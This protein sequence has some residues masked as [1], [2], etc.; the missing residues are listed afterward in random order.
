MP[1]NRGATWVA[2]KRVT[3]AQALTD[4]FRQDPPETRAGPIAVAVSGGSDSLGLLH[5]LRDWARAQADPP[6]LVAVT[7]DHGLRPAAAEEALRVSSICI[8]LGIPHDVLRWDDW[9]GAGNLQDQARRARYRLIGDW[10]QQAGIA[11]VALGHTRDDNIET[12]LMGLS[13]GA[14]L[15]GLSGM[16]RRFIRNAVEFHRPLLNTTRSALRQM[17]EARGQDWIDDPSNED[18]RF[19]R[20]RLRQALATLDLPLDQLARSIENLNATRRDLGDE[21]DARIGAACRMDGPDLL[22]PWDAF[23][24][25]SPEFR[26]RTLNAALRLISGA[27]YPPRAR[28]L[29]R[30]LDGRSGDAATLHGC[31]ITPG[32]DWLRIAREPAAVAGHRAPHSALWDRRWRV[33][34][35]T[36]PAQAPEIRALGAEGLQQ[37]G[38]LWRVTGVPRSSLMAS[39]ALWEGQMLLSAA[40]VSGS[41]AAPDAWQWQDQSGL[42][43]FRRL[44]LSH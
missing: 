1:D 38:D 37:C 29:A 3:P 11:H 33:A 36:K 10:A 42:S 21:L 26:R 27:E 23:A 35:R 25:L 30:L 44:L 2:A 41:G 16:R 9:D 5:A 22:I 39:P 13:R 8:P 31:V 14:G 20:V 4:H 6:A 12:F 15:D 28:Q 19:D 18:P 34:G 17:L 7:V 32:H 43:R 24:T 40:C